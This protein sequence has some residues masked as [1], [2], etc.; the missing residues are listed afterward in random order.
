MSN[1]TYH[2]QIIDV[3]RQ[4][5]VKYPARGVAQHLSEALTDYPHYWGL[6]DKEFLFA[7]DK[8]V[9]ELEENNPP[10]EKELQK[11]I[12]ESSTIDKL[13]NGIN[14]YDSEEEDNEDGD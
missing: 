1:K 4:L 14:E 12:D 11:L 10:P 5:K 7:L 3:L 6:S 8:Y 2:S 9:I 13:M